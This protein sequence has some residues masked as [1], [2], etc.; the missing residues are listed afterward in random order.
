[1]SKPGKPRRKI[2]RAAI[3]QSL[4]QS[5]HGDCH[6]LA[7]LEDYLVSAALHYAGV[8]KSP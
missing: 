6:V 5:V 1:M 4:Q 8:M 3:A 2:S 7:A